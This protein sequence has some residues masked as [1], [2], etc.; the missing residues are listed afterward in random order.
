MLKATFALLAIVLAGNAS[1]GWRS[2]RID[3]STEESF[4]A[5]VALLQDKLTPGRRAAFDRSLV[6][7]WTEGTRLADEQQRE[8]TAADYL[9]QLDGLSYEEVVKLTDPTGEQAKRYRAEYTPV[10]GAGGSAGGGSAP[11]AMWNVAAPPPV[12][13]GVYRGWTTNGGIRID[14]NACGC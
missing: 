2:L 12:Q 14:N 3:A 11:R 6:D 4:K 9:R 1:A 7:V 10:R 5:S 8:Y 13:N